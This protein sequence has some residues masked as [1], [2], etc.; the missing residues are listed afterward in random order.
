[1]GVG[2]YLINQGTIILLYNTIAIVMLSQFNFVSVFDPYRT[3]LRRYLDIDFLK[4]KYMIKK[5]LFIHT[6]KMSFLQYQPLSHSSYNDMI[7][8][9]NRKGLMEKPF[10]GMYYT[11]SILIFLQG[12]VG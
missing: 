10:S 5:K 1:M 2:V 6:D 12:V 3:C 11:S 7:N 4:I 9:G 8:T